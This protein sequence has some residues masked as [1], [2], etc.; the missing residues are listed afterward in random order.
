[1][2]I[3]Q[4]TQLAYLRQHFVLQAALRDP[5]ISSLGALAGKDDP[6]QWL[7]D[8]LDVSFPQNSEVLSISLSG[9]QDP[10]DLRTL[11]DAVTGAY[12]K[13]VVF[14]DQQRRN[15]T[16]DAL[17]KSLQKLNAEISTKMESRNDLA[18]E[19]GITSSLKQ[20]DPESELLMRDITDL[21]KSQSDLKA[22]VQDA[23]LN[24]LILQQP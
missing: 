12:L 8:E 13:E 18:K 10:E 14:K 16:H 17:A 20:R 6:V 3:L 4:R 23:Q 2:E 19:L 15:V 22:K 24:Y 9:K 21:S 1:F 7:T 11:V 5:A